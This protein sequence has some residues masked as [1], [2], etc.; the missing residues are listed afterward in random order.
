MGIPIQS[1]LE[2]QPS[3]TDLARALSASQP[4]SEYLHTGRG[5]AGNWY[6]PA[7]LTA[8][9]LEQ[10]ASPDA[11][12]PVSPPST[13]GIGISKRVLGGAKPAYRGGRGGAGNYTDFAEEERRRR[14]REEVERRETEERITRDV[15][16]GLARPPKAYGGR[17]GAWELGD[18]K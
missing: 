16:A 12:S 17:G 2:S 8:Q 7:E 1:D 5:G 6:Q 9:G 13:P 10:V 4:P 3:T 18:L 11:T 15:E 14:E